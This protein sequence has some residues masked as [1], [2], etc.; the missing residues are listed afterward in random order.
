MPPEVRL[1]RLRPA[2]V[3]AALERASV[4][5]IPLG[6][7]EYHA[8]HLP[9]GTDGFT[10]HGLRSRQRSAPAASCCPGAT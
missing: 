10:A 7:L 1:E 4:A 8:P 6:A 3:D 5:W 2:G 9:I